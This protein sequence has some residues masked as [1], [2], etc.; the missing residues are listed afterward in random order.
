LLTTGR[1]G[2]ARRSGYVHGTA[3]HQLPKLVGCELC[4]RAIIDNAAVAED[5]DA[6]G[7]CAVAAGSTPKPATVETVRESVD[8]RGVVAVEI[9]EG[10]AGH[11]AVRGTPRLP[12]MEPIWRA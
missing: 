10:A 11:F 1:A 6:I 3:R 7:Q 9:N 8:V 12:V 4:G 5:D 2:S